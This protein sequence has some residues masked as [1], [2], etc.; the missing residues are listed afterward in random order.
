MS[1]ID[2]DDDAMHLLVSA[3]HCDL[4]ISANGIKCQSAPK[5]LL[6]LNVLVIDVIKSAELTFVTQGNEGKTS[7]S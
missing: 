7:L 1:I 6:L 4:L 3:M 2:D 5:T